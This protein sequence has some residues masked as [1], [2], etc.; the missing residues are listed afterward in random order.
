MTGVE[1]GDGVGAGV[2]Y[3]SDNLRWLIGSPTAYFGAKEP[4][5]VLVSLVF[6]SVLGDPAYESS[7]S[8]DEAAGDADNAELFAINERTAKLVNVAQDVVR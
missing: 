5:I 2:T 4:R 1:L 3:V 6:Q 7:G 8:F